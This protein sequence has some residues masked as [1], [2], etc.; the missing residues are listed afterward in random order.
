MQHD[1]KVELVEFQESEQL[2]VKLDLAMLNIININKFFAGLDRAGSS[3]MAA[4]NAA[5][6]GRVRPWRISI[7]PALNLAS[8]ARG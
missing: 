6:A 5:S 4:R 8:G 3:L 2:G 1:L 7:W